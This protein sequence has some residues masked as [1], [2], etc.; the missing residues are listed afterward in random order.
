MWELSK[1]HYLCTLCIEN[2]KMLFCIQIHIL[3]DLG[4]KAPHDRFMSFCM[5]QSSRKPF[6]SPFYLIC[7]YS[8]EKKTSL[9]FT[10]F[11]HREDS[12]KCDKGLSSFPPLPTRSLFV[13]PPRHNM[14]RNKWNFSWKAAGAIHLCTYA[15]ETMSSKSLAINPVWIWSFIASLFG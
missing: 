7:I 14:A 9:H 15:I 3:E 2:Q 1:W 12:I 10:L 4:E 13:S 6:F 5:A 8:V 11:N